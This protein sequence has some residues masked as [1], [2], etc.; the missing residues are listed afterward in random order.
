MGQPNQ[1]HKTNISI[2]GESQFPYF[3]FI[4]DN[5]PSFPHGKSVH[6]TK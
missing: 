6:L 2:K 1:E 5:F 3:D 4:K